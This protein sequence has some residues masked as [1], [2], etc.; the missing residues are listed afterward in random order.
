MH[1]QTNNNMNTNTTKGFIAKAAM[2]LLLCVLTS[3]AVSAEQVEYIDDSGVKRTHTNPTVLTNS[4]TSLSAGW[5]VVENTVTDG[6]GIDVSFSSVLILSGDVHIILADG[7]EM[8]INSDTDGIDASESS[9]SLT[10]YGQSAGT[11]KLSI[12][13]TG[14]DNDNG[15]GIYA[16]NISI[17][18][19][20]ITI[21]SVNDGIVAI[22][23]TN[24][25]I[26]GGIVTVSPITQNNNGIYTESGDININ[27]G[28]V[29]VISTNT[30]NNTTY[31][32]K[33]KAYGNIN[34]GCKNKTDYIFACSY[35][36]SSGNNISIN[37]NLPII[38]GKT[39]YEN[40]HTF[41]SPQL[42][43]TFAPDLFGMSDGNDGTN[44]KPYTITSREGLQLLATFVNNGE[45]FYDS[46]NDRKNF[47]LCNDINMNGIAFEPIGIKKLI[48]ETNYEYPFCG[49]FNGESHTVSNVTISKNYGTIGL[50]G[51][52]SNG[53]TVKNIIVDHPTF[54]GNDTGGIVGYNVN[55]TVT[56]CIVCNAQITGKA[57][58]SG[59]IIGNNQG[60]L[61]YNYYSNCTANTATTNIGCGVSGD[62]TGDITKDDGAVGVTNA[63]IISETTSKD[64]WPSFAQNDEL[65]F[66]REFTGGTASTICM[67][68]AYTPNTS[69]GTF[70]T[71]EGIK[72]ETED[73]KTVYVATMQETNKAPSSPSVS[74]SANT[75]YLFKPAGTD[76]K[77]MMFHGPAAASN[78]DT[79]AGYTTKD[80]W[81]FIGTYAVVSWDDNNK[82]EGIYGFSAQAVE[83]QS[84]SQGQFVKVGEYVKIRSLRA[85][86]QY[87]GSSFPNTRGTLSE[88]EL[89]DRILVRL[90]DSL[91]HTT[92]IGELDM[93]T[94]E[95][96]FD[97]GWYTLEGI[98]LSGK[99]AKHGIYVNNGRKYMIK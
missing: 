1:P 18:G 6:D 4:M 38:D 98:R 21:K 57:N 48:G 50:F 93:K 85:Y 51:Y 3:T 40:N 75:P 74:L 72:T 11:G 66:Y 86:L 84:I 43:K 27:G 79:N 97:N 31:Y 7:A 52:L 95:V 94:G 20:I 68:F 32:S 87:T 37:S 26:N 49:A 13:A 56:N 96:T 70:Y 30:I 24:V 58:G 60:T 45:S 78:N 76:T 63:K 81:K 90:V 47:K 92:G 53:A 82:P 41:N 10:I 36:V 91:G 42:N 83:E 12:E 55:S 44:S 16:H 19:G 80:Y 29:S 89:P 69:D 61:K 65:F 88:E 28:K 14:T 2:T 23:G 62:K 54:S 39:L 17:N 71:F 35:E 77:L 25:N 9:G 73:D 67:P 34:L 15:M 22:S 8:S 59:A 46:Q 5:Y 33:I 64:S 99:P